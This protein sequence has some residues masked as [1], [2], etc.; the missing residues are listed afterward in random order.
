MDTTPDIP[1]ALTAPADALQPPSPT[2]R[3]YR[4]GVVLAGT[5]LAGLAAGAGIT[6]AV[7]DDTSSAVTTS[8]VAASTNAQ[9]AS[10]TTGTVKSALA[11]IEPSVV[12]IT[13]TITSNVRTGFGSA[14][15]QAEAAGTG[16]VISS[17]GEIVT[18]AHVVNDASNIQV[19]FSDGTKHPATLVGIDTAKDLAVIKA[20]GVT[21]AVPA[22]FATTVSVGDSVIAVGNAEGYGGSPSVTEGIISAT[23]RTLDGTDSSDATLTGLLQTDA[24]I[25]PGNSGGPLVNTDG[26]VVGINTAV[27]TG[28]SSEPAQGI[29]FAIPSSAVVAELPALK[30]GANA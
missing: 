13:D 20:T 25:N 17:D 30:A 10:S 4:F 24:A 5:V 16:I 8:T 12:L 9:A 3:R 15:Q 11:T 7:G 14:T 26:Q 19:T 21:D 18:N 1:D 23:N 22:S 6:A 28:T 27:A 2:S 29:G